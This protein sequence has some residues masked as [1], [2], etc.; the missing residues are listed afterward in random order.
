M[1]IPQLIAS[2]RTCRRFK[3][4]PVPPAMLESFAD[5]AR[6]SASARNMQVL[7]YILVSDQS[8]CRDLFKSLVFGGAISP[9]QRPTEEQMPRGYV[10]IAG[11]ESMDHFSVM[12]IGIAAQSV[13]LAAGEAGLGCCMLGAFSKDALA[14]LLGIPEGL[15]AKLVLAFGEPA[16]TR[17]IVGRRPDGKLTYYR[18]EKDE[19]CVPK[20]TIGEAVVRRI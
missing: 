13:L 16:E 18:N 14:D 7:R 15:E 11:P 17:K 4:D 6:L 19:H 2:S 3:G 9:A 12:D 10:V 1:T 5:C 8:A 20:I